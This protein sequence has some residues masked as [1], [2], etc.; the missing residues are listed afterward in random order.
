[1]EA[2]LTLV[3]V[4]VILAVYTH[5]LVFAGALRHPVFNLA[6]EGQYNHEKAWPSPPPSDPGVR[7]PRPFHLLGIQGVLLGLPPS[8]FKLLPGDTDV[9][10]ATTEGVAGP[11]GPAP[12]G[13]TH[14]QREALLTVAALETR[15]K[16]VSR[17]GESW[18][19]RQWGGP[20]F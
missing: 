14:E 5:S 19:A 3:P 18:G 10:V 17:V 11:A 7:H 12:H 20:R 13:R 4:A 16:V 2:A 9:A 1:M 8:H 6:Q 15:D